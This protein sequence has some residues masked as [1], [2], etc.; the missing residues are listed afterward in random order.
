[1]T[2]PWQEEAY[3]MAREALQEAYELIDSLRTQLCMALDRAERAEEA[4][5]L[6]REEIREARE[7]IRQARTTPFG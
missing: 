6:L 4:L 5:K 2:V 7:E 1:M 3:G